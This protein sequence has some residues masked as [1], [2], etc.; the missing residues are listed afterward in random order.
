MKEIQLTRG[1]V[2]LVD[3]ADY[4]WLNQ[5]KWFAQKFNNTFYAA[6]TRSETETITR[7]I[8]LMHR[9]IMETPDGMQVD[10]INHN[11][12]DNQRF[13]LR[14]CTQQENLWNREPKKGKELPK[15]ISIIRGTKYRARITVNYKE[16]H[17][18]HFD[19][20]EPAIEAYQKA[21]EFYFGDFR[22]KND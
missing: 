13:N 7:G 1:Q 12:I 9:V 21:S 17:L 15:G 11:G 3:D 5:W 10:H 20:L 2:A 19:E 16:I 4:T 22:Y 6:R 18:G 8:I 14:N